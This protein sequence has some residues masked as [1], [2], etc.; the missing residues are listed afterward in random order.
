MRAKTDHTG[1]QRLVDELDI[2]EEFYGVLDDKD[3][4]VCFILY[5]CSYLLIPRKHEHLPAQDQPAELTAWTSADRSLTTEP[6]LGENFLGRLC[7]YWQSLQPSTRS[8]GTDL[9]TLDFSHLRVGGPHGV[10]GLIV[11]LMWAVSD[12]AEE[13]DQRWLGLVCDI[14]LILRHMRQVPASAIIEQR[15][16]HMFCFVL[17]LTLG[18][19]NAPKAAKRK[20]PMAIEKG[21]NKRPRSSEYVPSV[22]FIEIFTHSY[23]AYR[24][25]SAPV[26]RS[27]KQPTVPE[28]P[29]RPTRERRS[30][31]G[32]DDVVKKVPAKGRSKVKKT[33]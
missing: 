15:Y 32:D 28:A 4:Y 31:P 5:H 3:D 6:T 18:N 19:S 9:T 12:V 27:R 1:W 8:S 25:S 26:T 21:A 29:S 24:T 16:I 17:G 2:F 23:D 22:P 33:R 20:A 11:M 10:Q 30:K 13:P 14:T 7:D